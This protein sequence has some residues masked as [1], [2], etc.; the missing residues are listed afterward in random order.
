[1]TQDLLVLTLQ[2]TKEGA[3]AAD[4][5]AA[6][7]RT[8]EQALVEARKSA[9]PGFLEVRTGGFTVQPRYGSTGKVN[10]WQGHAEI[11]LEGSDTGRLTQLAGRLNQMN[12]V[13]VGYGLSRALREQQ[14]SILTRQAI[15]R[16]KARAAQIA[17]DFGYKGYTLAEVSVSSTEPGFEGRPMVMAMRAKAVDMA[18]DAP[19]PVEPGKGTLS[20]VVNGQVSLTP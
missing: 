2:A 17:H 8:I 20:V 4:V 12:V 6:L 1:L 13:N 16:F 19:L 18:A 14:E 11:V 9:A 3:Q 10:G 5:Q 7:K 15:E